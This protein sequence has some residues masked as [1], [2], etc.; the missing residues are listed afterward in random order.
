[1]EDEG[2]ERGDTMKEIEAINK[3]IDLIVEN[4]EKFK[5]KDIE[6]LLPALDKAKKVINS[7]RKAVKNNGKSNRNKKTKARKKTGL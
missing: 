1:M 2:F 7:Y 3:M 5:V 6:D 4:P